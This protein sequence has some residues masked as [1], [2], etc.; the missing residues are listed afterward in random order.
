MDLIEMNFRQAKQQAAQLEELA[1]RLDNLAKKDLQETMQELSGVWKGENAEAYMR[2]GSRLGENIVA[3]AANLKQIAATIRT[4]A[5][6][7]YETEMRA[8]EIAIERKYG[9]GH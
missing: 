8:R 1:V 7:T 9:G 2:K 3:T 6:R 5:Q 4:T